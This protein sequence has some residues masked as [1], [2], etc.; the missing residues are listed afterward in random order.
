MTIWRTGRRVRQNLYRDDE[1]AGQMQ[2]PELAEEIANE[3]LNLSILRKR[4]ER[5]GHAST[6]QVGRTH[7]VHVEVNTQGWTLCGIDLFPPKVDERPGFNRGGGSS[8][9]DGPC[10]DCATVLRI[11]YPDTPLTGL[12]AEEIR[13]AS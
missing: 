9:T 3:F 6:I 11:Q 1:I 4:Q 13:E 7:H 5:P 12:G 10:E 8:P 2:T